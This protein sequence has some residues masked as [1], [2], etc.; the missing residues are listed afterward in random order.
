MSTSGSDE[1]SPKLADGLKAGGLDDSAESVGPA[2]APSDIPEE[3]RTLRQ[4]VE[5]SAESFYE[6]TATE[7]HPLAGSAADH[8]SAS[9]KTVAPNGKLIAGAVI[10]GGL[11]L[12]ALAYFFVPFR[13]DKTITPSRT[14]QPSA[15]VR[16]E[17]AAP[18]ASPA[19]PQQPSTSGPDSAPA[20][21]SPST[22]VQA[23]SAASPERTTS[24]AEVPAPVRPAQPARPPAEAPA[25]A[26][27][28]PDAPV[29]IAPPV[30]VPSPVAPAQVA[31][32]ASIPV[33]PARPATNSAALR[34][35]APVPQGGQTLFLQRPGVNIRSNPS[36]GANVVGSAPK[37]TR[38]EVTNRNGEWVQVESGRLKGWISARF[39][40]PNPPP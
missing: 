14:E 16:S 6:T 37:G 33:A 8:S 40:G 3:A 30:A 38:F 10:G 20:A 19:P 2:L 26:A 29:P 31:P 17:P 28:A 32:P 21:P 24:S 25:Q 36:T 7:Q 18:P 4:S 12:A 15:T 9:E 35:P 5:G 39:L 11:V 23:P 27:P 1:I 13:G 34:P 22:P